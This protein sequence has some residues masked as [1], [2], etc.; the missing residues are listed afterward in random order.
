[1]D[2]QTDGH[3]NLLWS[4]ENQNNDGAIFTVVVLFS[5]SVLL[6]LDPAIIKL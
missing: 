1:M 2:G 6:Y 5:A 3:S 4:L